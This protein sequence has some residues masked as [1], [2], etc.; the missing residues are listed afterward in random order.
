MGTLSATYQG[1]D[2]ESPH[3]SFEKYRFPFPN[4]DTIC[5]FAPSMPHLVHAAR[6]P[7]IWAR[8]SRR[9]DSII[10]FRFIVLKTTLSTFRENLQVI[11]DIKLSLQDCLTAYLTAALN[12]CSPAAV[13][14]I[15]NAAQYRQTL[16]A[17]PDLAGNPIYIIPT[18]SIDPQH[19]SD[20]LHIAQLI[21]RSI[22]QSRTTE[23]IEG[24]MS[25]ASKYMED[26]ANEDKQFFFGSE[27][28]VLTVNSTAIPW[29]SATFGSLGPV[30]VYKTGVSRFYLRISSA[31][32][33]PSYRSEEALDG[34]VGIPETM[35]SQFVESLPLNGDVLHVA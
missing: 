28:D 29:Q 31:N 5:E 19:S 4:N 30:Q 14:R 20:V 15:T 33:T 16:L 24:Y 7:E 1:I 32:A 6:G 21:R 11:S 35:Y 8:Y 25:T 18:E 10:P 27:L 2:K 3:P 22:T 23:F 26:A 9:N 12:R 13:R 34:C 17:S